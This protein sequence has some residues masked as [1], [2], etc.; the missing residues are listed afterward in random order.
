MPAGCY[1][2]AFADDLILVVRGRSKGDIETCAQ[3]ALDKLIAWADGHKL[4]FN[5]TKTTLLPVTFGGRLSLADPPRVSMMGH[6]VQV[7]SNFRY[8]GV[9]WDSSLTFTVHFNKVRSRVDLLSYRISMVA[10][11][12][13]SRRGRLFLRLYKGALE[14]FILYGHGAWGYR[15]RLQRIRTSLNSIQRKP[16]LR[17]TRAYRTVS[18][19]TL[20]VLAGVMPLD[21]KAKGVFATFLVSVAR[22]N[23]R[24]GTVTLRSADYLRRFNYTEVHPRSWHSIPYTSQEPTGFD[25]ELFSDGSKDAD[26]VGSSLVVFYHGTEIHHEECRL[27][28][29]ASVFQAES[30]GLRMA[31]TYVATLRSWVP[32][33]HTFFRC[34]GLHD[35]EV[36]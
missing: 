3:I 13:Y 11:R 12:F 6:E 34:D 20:Q 36:P 9:W 25:F 19:V 1:L 16:L 10:E 26:R 21:L 24:I 27:S 23:A 35:P 7:V 30:H 18:T 5:C 32:Q 8:L 15:L 17:I 4:Q 31:L 29:H 2:Q 33:G 22:V 14:P 28:D